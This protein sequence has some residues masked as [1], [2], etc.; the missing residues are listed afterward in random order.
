MRKLTFGFEGEPIPKGRPR[1]TCQTGTPKMYTGERTRQA[2]FDLAWA[3][4]AA[5]PGHEPF[6]EPLSV[7]LMF[8]TSKRREDRT[9][10]DIDNYA[11]TVLD[12]LNGIAWEDD[13][14]IVHLTTHI[15]PDLGTGPYT[16]VQI[17]TMEPAD[18]E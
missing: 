5:H 18:D 2:E 1:C 9:S 4:K 8:V 14:Q 16:N 3:F 7:L 11:K 15:S 17:R 12:A 6:T 13:R 10:G